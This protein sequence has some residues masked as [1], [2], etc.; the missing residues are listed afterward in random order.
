MMEFSCRWNGNPMGSSVIDMD[1][2]LDT[3]GRDEYRIETLRLTLRNTGH[4]VTAPTSGLCPI[5][6]FPSLRRPRSLPS[7]IVIRLWFPPAPPLH[8]PLQAPSRQC[9]EPE[10]PARWSCAHPGNREYPRVGNPAQGRLLP[11]RHCF[12]WNH[13][14][15]FIVTG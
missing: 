9:A 13:P 8:R 1:R 7:R 6:I 3:P 14:T 2:Q 4:F 5:R 12:H 11:P 15:D 10:T